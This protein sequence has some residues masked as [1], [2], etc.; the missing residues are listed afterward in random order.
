LSVKRHTILALYGGSFSPPHVGHTLMAA[1]IA[2]LPWVNNLLIVPSW[3]PSYKDTIAFKYRYE[4]CRTAFSGIAKAIVSDVEREHKFKYTYQT[5]HFLRQ[6]GQKIVLFVGS[7]W[8]IEKF[9]NYKQLI[10][11]CELYQF[12]RPGYGLEGKSFPLNVNLSSTAIRDC[13][14]R[15]QPITGAVHPGV[16]LYIKRGWLYV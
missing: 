15:E 1:Q 6:K 9:R 14:R 5:V 11:E 2:A 13:V 8:R 16:E 7:D 10:R 12:D 4:M 3:H